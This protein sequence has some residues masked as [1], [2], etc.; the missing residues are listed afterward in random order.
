MRQADLY[1]LVVM[2]I[3]HFH[4]RADTITA[5]WLRSKITYS[6][7]A[8][9]ESLAKFQG[10]GL[11]ERVTRYDW[12]L[13]AAGQQ[14][15]LPFVEQLSDKLTPLLA[16]SGGGSCLIDSESIE[17][18][19]TTT[20]TATPLLAESALQNTTAPVV[21]ALIK[22]LLELG[23]PED[24]A[25]EAVTKALNRHESAQVIAEKIIAGRRY[26]ETPAARGIFMRGHWLA[27]CLRD[28]R[29]IPEVRVNAED[30]NRYDGY[31]EVVGGD[32]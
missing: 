16:E 12:R 9:G 20:T 30:P 21:V 2:A 32:D 3:A 28:G 11:A 23:C 15:V 10:W 17:S 14:M 6:Q 31:L 24:R 4:L 8:I 18:I 19:N 1:V 26:V 27:A 29:A 13:T 7:D 25:I 22:P 5:K